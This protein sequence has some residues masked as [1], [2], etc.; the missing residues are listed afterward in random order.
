MPQLNYNLNNPLESNGTVHN[1][2]RAIAPKKTI[3]ISRLASDTSTDDVDYYLKSK[4]GPHADVLIHKFQYTQQRSIASFKLTISADLFQ[5]VLD[6][7]FWPENTLVRE[8][9]YRERQRL[10]NVGVLPQR[11]QNVS[12]N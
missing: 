10:N 5:L 7:N 3:F 8:Y 12:K 4:I 2:L 6:T 9:I 11:E 1:P